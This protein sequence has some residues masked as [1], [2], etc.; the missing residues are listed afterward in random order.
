MSIGGINGWKDIENRFQRCYGIGAMGA[1]LV[2]PDGFVAWR[3]PDRVNHPQ[4]QLKQ[5]VASILGR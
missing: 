5:V 4:I 2:R 3:S 1:T